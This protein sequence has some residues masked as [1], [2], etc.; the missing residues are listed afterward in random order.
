MI[1]ILE[2]TFFTTRVQQ[3]FS[4][5]DQIGA[6]LEF[7]GLMVLVPV[8]SSVGVQKQPCMLHV[9]TKHLWTLNLIYF[10]LS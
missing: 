9:P 7:V 4:V 8:L 5:E 2:N 3:T 1:D 6:V 10:H